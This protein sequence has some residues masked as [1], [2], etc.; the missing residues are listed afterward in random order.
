VRLAVEAASL[1]P[2]GAYNITAADTMADEETE[3]L[4]DRFYPQAPLQESLPGRASL[5]DCSRAAE[6]FG[7]RP[8]HSWREAL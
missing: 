6:A 2:G 7:F 8:R 4:I 5:F 3:S 1:P